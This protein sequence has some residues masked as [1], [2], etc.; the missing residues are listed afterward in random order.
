LHRAYRAAGIRA[1]Y[2]ACYAPGLDLRRQAA[3]TDLAVGPELYAEVAQGDH[4]FEDLLVGECALRD[5]GCRA[6]LL[7][8]WRR[9]RP[10]VV[11]LEQPYLWASVRDLLATEGLPRPKVIYSSQ[12]VEWD[13]KPA[14]YAARLSP[15]KAHA[16]SAKVR[17]LE[18][19]LVRRADLVVAASEADARRWPPWTGALMG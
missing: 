2:R 3:R 4:V 7:A 9:F 14:I 1:A 10:D 12:N 15:D 18:E 16:A 19:D 8:A 6:G 11:Q 13:M 17:A 5:P